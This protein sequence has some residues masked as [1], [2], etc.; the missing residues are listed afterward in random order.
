MNESYTNI[1]FARLFSLKENGMSEYFFKLFRDNI[2]M[3]VAFALIG[4]G[5]IFVGYMKVRIMICKSVLCSLN[6]KK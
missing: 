2:L 5:F 3:T 6:S 4:A 1:A